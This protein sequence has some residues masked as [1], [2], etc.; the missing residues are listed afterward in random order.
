MPTYRV[1]FNRRESVYSSAEIEVEADNT[2][3]AR[4]VAQEEA[5]CGN[6]VYE[7][8]DTEHEE[9]DIS[10]VEL[11]HPKP[12]PTTQGECSIMKTKL[13]VTKESLKK[14]GAC[15]G[16][17]SR[18]M[19]WHADRHIELQDDTKINLL[20]VLQSNGW[21]DFSWCLLRA[22][23][24]E[25][26]PK[27]LEMGKAIRIALWKKDGYPEEWIAQA[28]QE[29]EHFGQREWCD[30]FNHGANQDML[31]DHLCNDNRREKLLALMGA[32]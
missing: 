24:E 22:V 16:G 23:I 26:K 28:T 4:E 3:H 17:Y 32:A 10:E 11:L 19:E 14:A 12:Q 6:L 5:D 9:E 13:H 27:A 30:S 2:A 31:L 7:N 29:R 8:Y 25:D 1:T 20:T 15:T 18:L 21:G